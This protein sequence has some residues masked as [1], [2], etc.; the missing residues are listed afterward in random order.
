MKLKNLPLASFLAPRGRTWSSMAS[1]RSDFVSQH[2]SGNTVSNLGKQSSGGKYHLLAVSRFPHA[3]LSFN[4]HCSW[5]WTFFMYFKDPRHVDNV[6]C[7][8]SSCFFPADH[9]ESGKNAIKMK[10]KVFTPG[11]WCEP[12]LTDF[13]QLANSVNNLSWIKTIYN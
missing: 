7:H 4:Q 2:F 5:L 13:V 3:R 11:K 9:F 6:V 1:Q 12:S 10:V 8:C